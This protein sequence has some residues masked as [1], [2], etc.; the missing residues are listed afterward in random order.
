MST[1][2]QDNGGVLRKAP[3]YEFLSMTGK[4]DALVGI[5]EESKNIL[6]ELIRS[7][8]KERLAEVVANEG[9]DRVI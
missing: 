6:Q 1:L 7:P 5:A 9:V 4:D 2:S 3:F 8:P